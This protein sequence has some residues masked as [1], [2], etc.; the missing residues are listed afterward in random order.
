MTSV[1][2]V[3]FALN[4]IGTSVTSIAPSPAL[5]PLYSQADFNQ[6]GTIEHSEVLQCIE[7]FFYGHNRYSEEEIYQLIDYFLDQAE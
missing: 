1:L 7:E 2:S 3:L 4:F 6:D 5:P